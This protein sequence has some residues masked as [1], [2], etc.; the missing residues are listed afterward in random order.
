MYIYVASPYTHPDL[1][2]R[3]DRFLRA[4]QYTAELNLEGRWAFS[5]IVHCHEMAIRYELPVDFAYWMRFNGALLQPARELHVL[6]L[7][8]WEESRGVRFEIE[9]SEICQKPVTYVQP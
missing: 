1:T 3:T 9:F 8:G 4:M 6:Q 5:P 2:V 7:D